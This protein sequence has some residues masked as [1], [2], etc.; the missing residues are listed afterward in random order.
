MTSPFKVEHKISFVFLCP[1]VSLVY[2]GKF[3][4]FLAVGSGKILPSSRLFLLSLTI[5]NRVVNILRSVSEN[6]R[7]EIVM[8]DLTFC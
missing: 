1:S 8:A 7:Y 5:G 3:L 6:Q 2:T 4:S